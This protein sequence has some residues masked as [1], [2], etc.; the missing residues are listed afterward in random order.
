MTESAREDRGRGA[1]EDVPAQHPR[2]LHGEADEEHRDRGFPGRL[3]QHG[4]HEHQH[5]PGDPEPEV[6][7]ETSGVRTG[8]VGQ[9]QGRER[10]EGGE[11]GEDVV[12]DDLGPQREERRDDDR[13]SDRLPQAGP[14]R[15][16]DGAEDPIPY[17]P[18]H[19]LDGSGPDR[20][21]RA[22]CRG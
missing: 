1:G 18:G 5:A 2:D 9:G 21:G 13:G 3:G 16:V 20:C 19:R 6:R 17:V 12:A 8:E 7:P 4:A 11:E 14:I 15:V 22:G 10:A